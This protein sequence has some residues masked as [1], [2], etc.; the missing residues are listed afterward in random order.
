[1]A[2]RVVHI[3]KLLIVASV[4]VMTLF[5]VVWWLVYLSLPQTE[6]EVAIE[7]L[8]QPVSIRFDAWQRPYV[9]AFSLADALQAQG[10]LHAQNR[11]W[12]MELLR[13][14][15]RGHMAELLGTDLLATDR[16]LWRVGVPQLAAALEENS[17]AQTLTLIDH[18]VRGV[19]A[20]I[21]A[22]VIL[23]PEFL[24]LAAPRPLWQ[25][26]D[27]FA[28]GAL[29]AYQSANNMDN[30]LLRLALAGQLDTERFAVFLSDDL[31]QDYPFIIP[32]PAGM[33][34]LFDTMDR[35][36]LTSPDSNPW[37][38]RLGFGSN[39][40]VVSAAKSAS[41]YPLYAFDSHDELGLPNL[42]YEV[43]L[44][45]GMGRQLRGWSVA[46]L[47]GVINGFNESIAW[48]F[49]NI[50]DT[51]DLFV[52]TRSADNPLLF[53][54]GDAWY[55]A[56]TETVRIPVKGRASEEFTV[57]YTRNGPLINEDP[58]ISLAWTV[59]RIAQPSLDSILALNFAQDWTAFTAALDEFPAPTL[60]ATYADVHG[61]IGFRTAGIIPQRGAGEGLLPL[62]GSVSSN[63]WQ[64]MVPAAQM[65]QLKNPASGF[66]AAANARVNA[67]GDGP[68]VSAD[69]APP[70]RI[71]RIHQMLS[72]RDRLTIDDMQDLQMD[73]T[74]G[75][76]QQ[77]LPTMLA[78]LDRQRL[79]SDAAAALPILEQWVVDPQ[80]GRDSAG[81]LIFQQWYLAT[82][83][84][85]F[86]DSIPKLYPRL[87][88]RSYVLNDALDHL[89]LHQPASVW[90][91]GGQAQL[92]ADGLNA[93]VRDL[94]PRLGSDPQMWRLD[95]RLYVRMQH[96]LAKA[97]PQLDWLFNRP[98][99]P[100][101]GSTATVGRARYSYLD[102]FVVTSGATVRA[103][104][105]MAPV[106]RAWSVMPGGQ[107]G[108][109]LSPYY[110]DQYPGWLSGELYPIAPLPE[111]VGGT[112]LQLVPRS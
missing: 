81:A 89:L 7:G 17:S 3:G 85:V 66:L 4:L 11:L 88:K 84:V 108:H 5:L 72:K 26:R 39:G 8:E 20:A 90:W 14:A 51:Q 65:P 13:R 104:A 80:A 36:A 105:E 75:Q 52:E 53:K 56:R 25:R 91:Q 34:G 96:Q 42:F 30:E 74:D 47:P 41:G 29:M 27:V 101:G 106:P 99:E 55:P 93:A 103:V 62:D 6:G 59:H 77:V 50:G 9:Q 83:A 1:M 12:Q 94:A 43:H 87:L 58:P 73:W 110:V 33:A 57:T 15:G 49:T 2:T 31:E 102:P 32:P 70:Y 54:D 95:Q 16:E 35:L 82:A 78:Q 61:T 92:L 67:P 107:S 64:D 48:G 46:G 71:A 69:N 60:N 79:D 76:A 111:A 24:L 22:Y 19:N 23:P 86:A 37:M 28:L 63:R 38:P 68:L 97:V 44:F 10:W 40:W 98:D 109:P 100:W 45:F 112:Q 21:E 18:Y